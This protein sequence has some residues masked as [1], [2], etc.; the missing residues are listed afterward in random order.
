[1]FLPC[2]K[3]EYLPTKKELARKYYQVF[4]KAIGKKRLNKIIEMFLETGLI[5]EDRDPDD[6]RVTVYSHP[7][8]YFNDKKLANSNLNKNPMECD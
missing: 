1:M 6:R 5:I 2:L 7:E 4:Y 8:G 3:E